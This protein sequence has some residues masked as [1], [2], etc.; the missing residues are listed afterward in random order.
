MKRILLFAATNIAV[1]V[2]MAII[3][4]LLSLDEFLTERGESLGGPFATVRGCA[5]W[6][7]LRMPEVGVR[8]R[9]A[10]DECVRGATPC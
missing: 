9:L 10:R 8:V 3:V 5:Q 6:L 4:T 2:V 1:L 7:G